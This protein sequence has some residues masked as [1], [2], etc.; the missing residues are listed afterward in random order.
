VAQDWDTFH[1]QIGV[2][3]TVKP[4]QLS[5]MQ[6]LVML[7]RVWWH[8]DM[9]VKE[10]CVQISLSQQSNH[11]YSDKTPV[12]R[13][14]SAW[15]LGLEPETCGATAFLA[16]PRISRLIP[17]QREQF[18]DDHPCS[19]LTNLNVVIKYTS[20]NEFRCP[21][22]P[23]FMHDD[24]GAAG[25]DQERDGGGE[26]RRFNLALLSLLKPATFKLSGIF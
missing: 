16:R 24:S 21:S 7:R 13:S 5:L 18:L 22:S 25:F 20:E 10:V 26:S 11:A 15:V 17:I 8:G 1:I 12:V 3:G 19:S 2:F 6:Y 9:L 23:S 14:D 4:D